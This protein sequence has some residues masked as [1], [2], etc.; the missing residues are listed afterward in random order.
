MD[1]GTFGRK[2]RLIKEERHDTYRSKAKLPE[3]SL[4]NGCGALFAN[5]RWSWSEPPEK[6][7]D[8]TC[9]ACRRIADKYPAGT[10][11]MGGLFY[12]QHRDEIWN[13]IHN[14]EKQEKQ[15]RPLERIMNITDEGAQTVVT[16]TGVHLARRI[17]EALARSYQGDFSF[18]YADAENSIRGRWQRD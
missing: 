11:E 9:P 3:P 6:S 13:L 2:D 1:K 5:G 12:Q 8:T 7:H 10:L 4:C 15:E 18:Q 14:T 17:G 16:T